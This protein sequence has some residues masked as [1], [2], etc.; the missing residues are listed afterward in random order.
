MKRFIS[1]LMLLSILVLCFASCEDTKKNDDPV[2][3]ALSAEG[4]PFQF[5][6]Q[7]NEKGYASYAVVYAWTEVTPVITI[8][9]TITYNGHEYPVTG[10]GLGQGI[11][12]EPSVVEAVVFSKNVKTIGISAFT[13]CENLTSIKFEEGLEEIGDNAFS[14]ANVS[15]IEF[16]STLKTIGRGAFSSC[17]ELTTV[18]FN[19]NIETIAN[20]A[21]SLCSSLDLISIPRKFAG[22]IADIFPFCNTVID[23]TCRVTYPD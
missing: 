5:Y 4:V 18:I 19:K 12:P 23:N 3:V 1:L 6:L 21:F 8:P 20:K 2:G 17:T 15:Y 22:S 10:V 11:T 9:E 16:P 13:C 7:P 14:Y